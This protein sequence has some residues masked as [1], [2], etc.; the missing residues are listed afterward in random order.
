MKE[1]TAQIIQPYLSFNGRCEEAVEFYRK[2]IGA[3]VQMMMRF[4]DSPE[5]A[6]PGM[7][8][9]GYENKIMHTSLLVGGSV[10][11]ASDGCSNEKTNFSGFS[12]S[13]T[14]P[15]ADEANRT[16]DALSDGGKVSMPLAKTFWSP[17]LGMVQDKFGLNWMVTMPHGE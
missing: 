11:M 13:L 10:L 17:L 1:T 7:L 15:T 2:A 8:P 3:E 6:K 4:K 12:L 14:L 16:F 5:P 9:P